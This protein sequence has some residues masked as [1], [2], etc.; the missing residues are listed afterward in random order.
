MLPAPA[1]HLMS[2]D[3]L[4]MPVGR[5]AT[6]GSTASPKS[7]R[8]G[9]CT[10]AGLAMSFTAKITGTHCQREK[11]TRPN[12][13]ALSTQSRVH[14]APKTRAI[15]GLVV[16]EHRA[17]DT[18][19]KS[20]FVRRSRF[21]CAPRINRGSSPHSSRRHCASPYCCASCPRP[22]CPCNRRHRQSLA[23]L[24]TTNVRGT[25]TAPH[26]PVSWQRR[27]ES[28]DMLSLGRWL[29]RRKRLTFHAARGHVGVGPHSLRHQWMSSAA[30]RKDWSSHLHLHWPA[31]TLPPP[32]AW[33]SQEACASVDLRLVEESLL[34][35]FLYLDAHDFSGP[36][37]Q[38]GEIHLTKHDGP[39]I[40]TCCKMRV[41]PKS[42]AII[43]I[44]P[45]T[46]LAERDSAGQTEL[47]FHVSDALSFP[48]LPLRAFAASRGLV[49]KVGEDW[50]R[51]TW[52]T[53]QEKHRRQS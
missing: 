12:I 48:T 29:S 3:Q 41:A 13:A 33:S 1:P 51:A 34:C 46:G 45:L 49:P 38:S 5:S 19:L 42:L 36:T 16:H 20:V 50:C 27:G 4:P 31:P 8:H 24:K 17:Y 35:V 28:K 14:S 23:P 47:Q 43:P 32:S 15:T 6:L 39:Y 18:C 52:G 30:H 11:Q 7:A 9:S 2:P 21:Y 26:V 44:R 37:D 25:A 53:S 22:V 40:C 10:L